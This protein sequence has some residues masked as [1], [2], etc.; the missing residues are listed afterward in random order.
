MYL[1]GTYTQNKIFRRNQKRQNR[2]GSSVQY[3]QVEMDALLATE[4]NRFHGYMLSGLLMS[5]KA[6]RQIFYPTFAATSHG[7]SK[8]GMD[9]LSSYGFSTPHTSFYRQRDELLARCRTTARYQQFIIIFHTTHVTLFFFSEVCMGPYVMWIDNYDSMFRTRIANIKQNSYRDCHWTGVAVRKHL[10]NVDVSVVRDHNNGIVP[11]MPPDPLVFA[12]RVVEMVLIGSIGR[13][14]GDGR[15]VREVPDLYSTSLMVTWG[16]DRVPLKPSI[17]NPNV[18]QRYRDAIRRAPDS[19]GNFYALGMIGENIGSNLGLARVMRQFYDSNELGNDTSTRYYAMSMDKNIHKRKLRVHPSLFFST[20]LIRI[21]ILVLSSVAHVRRLK[22]G[23]SSAQVRQCEPQLVAYPEACLAHRMEKVCGYP[24][25]TPLARTVPNV[26]VL[27]KQ[28]EPTGR[29]R[30]YG[31]R[32]KCLPNSASGLQ[33]PETGPDVH[34]EYPGSSEQ[35]SLPVR[36]CNPSGQ[37]CTSILIFP[38]N[39]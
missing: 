30:S 7:L 20:P 9:L 16:V 36:V 34:P 32:R 2:D 29:A 17:R 39:S 13:L 18:P 15:T 5:G 4:G 23:A 28:P 27:Q 12:G 10:G 38:L 37:L 22:W 25:G 26:D 35:P 14:T 33:R 19:L 1:L 31:A 21:L 8:S 3:T 24:L 6:R 11:A